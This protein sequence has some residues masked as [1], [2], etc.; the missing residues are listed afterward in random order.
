MYFEVDEESSEYKKI[1][2]QV[3]TNQDMFFV[4]KI[5]YFQEAKTTFFKAIT[6]YEKTSGPAITFQKIK[7]N[8][9]VDSSFTT[10]R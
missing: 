8:G 1:D 10:L 5:K 7:P 6:I 4:G 3:F 2:P 9:P